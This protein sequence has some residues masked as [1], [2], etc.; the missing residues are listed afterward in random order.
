MAQL[1]EF[2]G[3]SKIY[4]M[5]GM[6]Q[7][8]LDNISFLIEEGEFVVILGQSG[9]GKTTLL[10]LIGGMD[11]LTE[12]KITVGH[13]QLHKLN[14]NGLTE[15]RANQVGF[16]FQFYNLIPTLTAYENVSL[17]KEIVK[18]SIPVEEVK[19]ETKGWNSGQEKTDCREAAKEGVEGISRM[20]RSRRMQAKGKSG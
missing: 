7:R 18:D 6:E 11:K 4:H 17:I 3:V 5:E 16:I 10:N 15:Y 12:G 20:K 14:D 13:T 2:S 19:F 1:I 9:A 8:A